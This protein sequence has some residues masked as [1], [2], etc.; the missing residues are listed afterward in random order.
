M[1]SPHQGSGGGNES[2]LLPSRTLR[3]VPRDRM[4]KPA[5]TP[6]RGRFLSEATAQRLLELLFQFARAAGNT[7]LGA[8]PEVDGLVR[9]AAAEIET[10]R[11]QWPLIAA[12]IN[13]RI[14]AAL[15]DTE[16]H[17]AELSPREGPSTVAHHPLGDVLCQL[18]HTLR[19]VHPHAMGLLALWLEGFDDRD[20]AERLGLGRRLVRQ[21]RAD[22][23]AA[24]TNCLRP[25]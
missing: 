3:P 23:H 15:A 14:A 20:A 12:E 5:A 25:P 9:A 8:M 17:G 13:A 19:P 18:T 6:A 4:M 22:A 24:W 2:S 7:P 10:P 21:I 16:S 11:P 1:A